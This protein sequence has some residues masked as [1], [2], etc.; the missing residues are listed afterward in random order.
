M[1]GGARHHV[2]LLDYHRRAIETVTADVNRPM[3][4]KP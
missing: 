2:T 1:A 4:W 3:N